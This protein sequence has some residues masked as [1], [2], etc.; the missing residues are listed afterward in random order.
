MRRYINVSLVIVSGII[1]LYHRMIEPLH[2][3]II[4][5]SMIAFSLIMVIKYRKIHRQTYFHLLAILILSV[6]LVSTQDFA[7]NLKSNQLFSSIFF[8]FSVAFFVSATVVAFELVEDRNIKKRMNKLLY[9]YAFWILVFHSPFTEFL[10][11]FIRNFAAPIPDDI[12]NAISDF[13]LISDITYTIVILI[14]GY[15]MYLTD[16]EYEYRKNHTYNYKNDK[17]HIPISDFIQD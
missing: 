17:K 2:L 14:Q 1:V 4:I 6:Y 8:L 13:W 7:E 10:T 12:T 15:V 16:K 9:I 11:I 5:L 3:G